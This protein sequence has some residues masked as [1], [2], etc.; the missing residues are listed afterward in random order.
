MY[1]EFAAKR[2]RLL[3]KA[4][5][6]LKESQECIYDA[7]YDEV[8]QVYSLSMEHWAEQI[9]EVLEGLDPIV[10]EPED[11]AEIADEFLYG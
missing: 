11:E 5:G 10:S 4:Y 6:L 8:D 1:D 3:K 2:Q 7:L 9:G